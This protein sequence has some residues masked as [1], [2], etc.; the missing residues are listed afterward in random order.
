MTAQEYEELLSDMESE[1]G[2]I[3]LL[4]RVKVIRTGQEKL[5][6]EV[7]SVFAEFGDL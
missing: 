4:K 5:G 1:L 2:A 6:A 7:G 3:P